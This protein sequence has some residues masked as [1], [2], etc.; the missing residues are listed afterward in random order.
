MSPQ[1]KVAAGLLWSVLAACPVQA[2]NARSEP[3]QNPPGVGEVAIPSLPPLP[4]INDAAY[5]QAVEQAAPL[6]PAQIKNL[7]QQVDA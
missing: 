4:D 2:E 3:A 7:R 1:I 5:Q 6:T